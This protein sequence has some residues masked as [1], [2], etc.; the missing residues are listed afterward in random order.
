MSPLMLLVLE[1]DGAAPGEADF[2]TGLAV[3][4]VS[5]LCDKDQRQ[6]MMI[7]LGVSAE[8]RHVECLSLLEFGH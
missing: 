1:P 7:I 6:G 5:A 3:C 2:P 8:L 4:W